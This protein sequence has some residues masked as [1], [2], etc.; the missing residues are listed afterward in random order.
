[1]TNP[2]FLTT[3]DRM[4]KFEDENDQTWEVTLGR[5]S[6][7]TF[8]LL[9]SRPEGGEV[10]KTVLASETIYDAQAELEAL[11]IAELRERLAASQSWG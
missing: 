6:W 4:R 5:E 8:V 7:G 10:R 11:T 2:L 1:M 3:G 9:F